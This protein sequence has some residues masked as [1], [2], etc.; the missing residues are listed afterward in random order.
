M[1]PTPSSEINHRL[2]VAIAGL[3][4]VGSGV[5]HLLVEQAKRITERTGHNIQ[6]V[7]AVVK[8]LSK[9][10]SISLPDDVLTTSLDRVFADDIDIVLELIGGTTL[11]YEI[12]AK[13]LRA[14]KHVVTANKALLCERGSELFAIA[15]EHNVT[16]AFEAAV[17]GGVPIIEAVA[18]SLSA[19]QVTSMQG[20]LN[21]TCN[22]ILT[23]MFERDVSYEDAV[24]L[25]QEKGYAE[26]DPSMDVEG[27]DAAQKLTILTQL[28]YGTK[29][30]LSEF[31]VQGI[32]TL[33]LDD[34]KFADMLGYRIKL[35][36]T[37]RLT[38]GQ[39]EMHT[40]PTL[41][42]QQR[43][44]ADVADAYNM[45]EVEGDAVGRTWFSGMGAGQMPTAS[46]V[47]SDVVSLA[48]GRAQLTFQH[49]N[50]WG[51]Q[52]PLAVL[53]A[54]KIERRY[55]LRFNA[56]DKPHTLADITHILGTNEISIAS[57]VQHETVAPHGE[58]TEPLVP[59]VIMT[60]TTTEGQMS[61]ADKQ[62]AASDK[63]RAPY[64]RLP[65]R[66]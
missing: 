62:L 42:R 53:P 6:L 39:L 41:I 44:M 63:V 4:T 25:A 34:L 13:S 24:K 17:A 18:Q 21:G 46:A 54:E 49:L 12:V 47:V 30:P 61:A 8:D 50:L 19:N 9:P 56:V 29:V 58:E 22:F 48:V 60:H 32:D 43:P 15:R 2:N 26:A 28:A 23:E 31:I 59:L 5:A 57:C 14:G 45:V 55:Y 52:E 1:T 7:A 38:E 64:V 10:R 66:E 51:Q 36:A 35:L 37:A 33:D 3:G 11:A 20:I 65:I 40:Q 16:I 27:T